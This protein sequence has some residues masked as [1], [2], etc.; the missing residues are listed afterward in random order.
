MTIRYK[1]GLWLF[2]LPG[3]AEN[4]KVFHQDRVGNWLLTPFQRKIGIQYF[5]SSIYRR[6]FAKMGEWKGG[7]GCYGRRAAPKSLLEIIQS[8]APGGRRAARQT[9]LLSSAEMLRNSTGYAY[10]WSP[11]M[12]YKSQPPYAKLV[13]IVREKKYRP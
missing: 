13:A 1:Y 4:K 6:S 8:N 12:Q 11:R 7:F 3:G 5:P 10:L 2:F 9:Q